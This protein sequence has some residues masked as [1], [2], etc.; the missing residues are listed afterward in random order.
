MQH[1][2]FFDHS[3]LLGIMRAKGLTRDEFA[4]RFGISKT[5]MDKKLSGETS[6]KDTDIAK[7]ME[8]LDLNWEKAAMC[9]FTPRQSTNANNF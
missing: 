9:F 1:K 4:R 5:A 2:G 8:I 7:A 3:E 6:W